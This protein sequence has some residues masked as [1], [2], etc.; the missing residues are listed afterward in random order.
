MHKKDYRLTQNHEYCTI[1]M[2]VAWKILF[3]QLYN[4]YK[5]F[6]VPG[7]QSCEHPIYEEVVLSSSHNICGQKSEVYEECINVQYNK[8]YDAPSS[9]LHNNQ[10]KTINLQDNIAY[11]SVN[12][13]K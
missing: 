12:S 9:A 6:I 4:H 13:V 11:A 1:Y 8:S 10:S 7:K 3:V 2:F 5:I